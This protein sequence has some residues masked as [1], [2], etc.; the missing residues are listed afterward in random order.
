MK[1]WRSSTRS[2]YDTY[3]RRWISHCESL[4]INVFSPTISE[5]LEFLLKN[6]RENEYSYS[7]MNSFRSALST[8]I[9]IDKVPA[10]K[11]PL[12]VRFCRACFNERP[13]LP[14]NTVTWDTDIV[15]RY[16]RTL[17][18]VKSLPLPRLTQKLTMLLALLSGQRCQSL[19][20]LDVR[21]MTL[22]FSAVSFQIGDVVKQTRPGKHT[23][24]LA[25]KGY[26]P[27]R[28]LCVVTVLKEY[29][30][31]TLDTRGTTKQL[32]LT[33]RKPIHAASVDTIRRWVKAVLINA[34][35]NMTIFTPHSTRGA[36]TSKAATKL[37]L[38]T[39]L[40]TAGW[41]REGTFT[42][43]YKLKVDTKFDFGSSLL[44]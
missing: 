9:T 11:H 22:S 1:G 33:Y 18:P 42:K 36:S 5:I 35:V 44:K 17:A 26:A 7:S 15:L 13:A 10:G 34:G 40:D 28:R 37:P 43:Y 2:Q 20:L 29:L 16:L 31:R 6:F 38:K 23:N 24:E 30:R 4:D 39:I 27:D 32:L 14:K 25:F 19:H 41:S 12:V 3:L 8:I 21:N